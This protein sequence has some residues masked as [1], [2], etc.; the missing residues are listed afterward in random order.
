VLEVLDVNGFSIE[1]LE[2]MEHLEH[3]STSFT[4]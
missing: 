1:H 2:H 4:S 3:L